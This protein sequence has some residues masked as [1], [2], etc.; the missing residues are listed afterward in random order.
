MPTERPVI[1]FFDADETLI[2]MKSPF[3]MLRWR[4]RREGDDGSRYEAVTEPIRRL[5]RL[6]LT[7]AE[8]LDAFYAVFAG[9]RWSDLLDEGREWF[10]DLEA[11]GV[12]LIESA[13]S[14]LRAHQDAGHLTAIVSGAWAASLHPLAEFLGVDA[15]V[16]TEPALDAGGRLTG[17]IGR[18][19]FGA[20]KSGA[21][22]ELLRRF[23]ADPRDC[24][25]YADDPGDLP[26]LEQ[27]GRA[28]V[29]GDHPRMLQ[30]A[31]QRGWQVRSAATMRDTVRQPV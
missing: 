20:A 13:V 9:E 5:A 26:M 29:I 17:S 14:A 6:G 31:A 15:V 23:G 1:A 4:L 8:V 10:R 2:A 7:P 16:C 21:V 22:Q 11:E 30:L 12:P 24:H 25:G 3:S 18:P 19:M 27:L 28:T